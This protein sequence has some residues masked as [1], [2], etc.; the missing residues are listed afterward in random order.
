MCSCA[1]LRFFPLGVNGSFSFRMPFSPSTPSSLSYTHCSTFCSGAFS[2]IAFRVA[3][4]SSV[5]FP[6]LV[7]VTIL[8]AC[9]SIWYSRPL[10]SFR[11]LLIR[12]IHRLFCPSSAPWV[13]FSSKASA[14]ASASLSSRSTSPP[15]NASLSA[16]SPVCRITASSASFPMLSNCSCSI[17]YTGSTVIP[18]SFRY[19]SCTPV[20]RC[21]F[22]A[23][24]SRLRLLAS[25]TPARCTAALFTNFPSNASQLASYTR[26]SKSRMAL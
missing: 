19:A 22:C 2:R 7:S 3:S 15:S 9:S 17:R 6:A 11:S 12:S 26:F 20:S 4:T 10:F 8:Y 21:I 18:L 25:S 1:K 23:S 14:A 16:A 24:S 5:C 13:Y